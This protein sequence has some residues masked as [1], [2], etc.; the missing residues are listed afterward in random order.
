MGKKGHIERACRGKQKAAKQKFSKMPGTKNKKNVYKMQSK[1][2]YTDDTDSSS[3]EVPLKILAVEGDAKGYW[4][5]PLIEGELVC[6]EIDTGAAVSI[7]SDAVYH[8]TL[9][10]V[11]L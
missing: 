6:M 2:K 8:R 7:V 11:Y 10:H 9:K 1:C 5:T 4:V 3:E